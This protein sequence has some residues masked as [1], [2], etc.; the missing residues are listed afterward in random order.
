[1]E[2]TKK[3][4]T[5]YQ[6]SI[7]RPG[8][9]DT[10]LIKGLVKNP[11][12]KKFIN[13]QMMNLFPN[14]EQIGF[15]DFDQETNT[16]TLEMAGGEFCGN[17][18]RSLAYLLLDEKKGEI[19]VKV[20]GTAQCLR[21]GIRKNCTAYAQMPIQKD[22]LIAKLQKGL[23]RINLEGITQLVCLDKIPSENPDKLKSTALQ[24]L[25]AEGLIYSVPAAGIMFIEEKNKLIKLKP[26][27]WVRDIETIFF[28]TSCATGT[29]AIGIWK[30]YQ[31][32]KIK[33]QVKILQPSGKTIEAIVN[34]KPL[35]VFID[36][37]IEI[38]FKGG[39]NYECK[40]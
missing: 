27:V 18:T 34:K 7:L 39:E 2:K 32:T 12:R 15:Y 30:A 16:A 36:G 1:M 24:I 29:A 13:D 11:V 33:T 25:K 31:T 35:E 4:K 5:K 23:F 14:V 26:I 22:S 20:S 17:A 8:G 3:D 37:P 9:N 40:C 10:M 6:I 38:L 28:E 19:Y 21:A